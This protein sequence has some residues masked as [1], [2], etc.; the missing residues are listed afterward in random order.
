ME[1]RGTKEATTLTDLSA[2]RTPCLNRTACSKGL[3]FG[4]KMMH[5]VALTLVAR[6]MQ[7]TA[8]LRGV[9]VAA[10]AK[11]IKRIEH[12][13]HGATFTV[14]CLRHRSIWSPSRQYQHLVM[15]LLWRG[16]GLVKRMRTVAMWVGRLTQ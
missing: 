8:E 3:V 9:V 1:E 12:Q 13:A 2:V 10:Q 7:A 5:T 15:L 4:L 14:A 6:L 16:G 11:S